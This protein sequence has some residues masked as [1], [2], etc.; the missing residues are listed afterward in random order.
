MIQSEPDYPGRRL[1]SRRRLRMLLYLP[2]LA[3]PNTTARIQLPEYNCP[4][5]TNDKGVSR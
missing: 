4:S 3:Y 1:S 5:V 2:S